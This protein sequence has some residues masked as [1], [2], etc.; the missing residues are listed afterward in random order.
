MEL[1]DGRNT[2][3]KHEYYCGNTYRRW[4]CHWC[5]EEHFAPYIQLELIFLQQD[6][7]AFARIKCDQISGTMKNRHLRVTL[8]NRYQRKVQ[9]DE[10][11]AEDNR[12]FER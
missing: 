4:R 5:N 12:E 2:Y 6:N 3:T 9:I 7:T 10:Y 11:P 1:Y 8:C